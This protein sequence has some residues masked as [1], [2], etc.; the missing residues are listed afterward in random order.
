MKRKWLIWFLLLLI[1]GGLAAYFLLAEAT[2]KQRYLYISSTAATKEAVLD[3][4]KLNNFISSPAL[5][6]FVA[7]RL[8]YWDDIKP[9][10]YEIKGKNLISVVRMLRNGQ[11]APVKLVITKL[12]TKK[13]LAAVLGKFFEPDS[14]AVMAFLNNNDSVKKWNVDTATVISL[15]V[16]DTYNFYWN[17]SAQTLLK[18][19][20][21]YSE[22]FW[23]AER[24]AKAA[25]KGLTPQQA[26]TV[27]SIVEEETNNN[28]EKGNVASVYLNRLQKGMPLQADPT[29][30]FA[31]GDFTLKRI[32]EKHL[33]YPS[34]YNT[35][36]NKGLPPGPICTPSKTTLNAVLDAPQTPYFYFVASPAFDGTH[37]FSATYPEHLQKAKAYQQALN[38]EAAKSK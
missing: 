2:G 36:R 22:K 18:R 37:Q 17:S 29:V 21:S 35:Y 13:D 26:Y 31:I 1:A 34:P 32:Y 20:A 19:F 3:S 33:L 9:G 5:F 7:D 38:E 23:T 6:S 12:R 28:A 24:K 30:K 4:L 25:K 16:P 10:R 8:G 27:A 15:I 14:A 11:Q